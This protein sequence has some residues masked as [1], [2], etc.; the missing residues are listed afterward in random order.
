[1]FVKQ[2][3]KQPVLCTEE[4]A[5]GMRATGCYA[6]V[7]QHANNSTTKGATRNAQQATHKPRQ[8]CM[9]WLVWQLLRAVEGFAHVHA[10]HGGL[11]VW[12][13]LFSL[14]FLHLV[15]EPVARVKGFRQELRRVVVVLN[16]VC[17]CL[18]EF[19][20]DPFVCFCRLISLSKQC[21]KDQKQIWA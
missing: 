3:V 18:G 17:E 11:W 20:D 4:R 1:M 13:N 7:A 12:A 9:N 6:N 19:V 16:F 21:N 14:L 8:S 10:L 15:E 5:V 2:K